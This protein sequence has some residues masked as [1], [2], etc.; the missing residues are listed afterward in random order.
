[1]LEEACNLLSDDVKAISRIAESNLNAL[2]TVHLGPKRL[3]SVG[4][5]SLWARLAGPRFAA[6]VAT[7][8]SRK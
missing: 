1:V 7:A 3:F 5:C 6:Q 8:V 2:N 4:E